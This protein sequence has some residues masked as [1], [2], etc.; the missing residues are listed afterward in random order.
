MTRA[1]RNKITW[2][3][4]CGMI[5][6]SRVWSRK[7][8]VTFS[9]HPRTREASARTS[10][11]GSI[12][13]AQTCEKASS[14]SW[15]KNPFCDFTVLSTYKICDAKQNIRKVTRLD[16][17]SQIS[18]WF[19]RP[20]VELLDHYFGRVRQFVHSWLNSDATQT[21]KFLIA[22]PLQ[23]YEFVDHSASIVAQLRVQ[24]RDSFFL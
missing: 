2:N 23:E 5:F 9:K 10:F 14:W 3:W 13:A 6:L 4:G 11:S 15:M 7:C 1:I 19:S 16:K 8:S 17:H 12:I 21:R 24:S 22:V 18:G 20:R